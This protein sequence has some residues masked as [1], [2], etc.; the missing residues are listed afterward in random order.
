MIEGNKVVDVRKREMGTA[1]KIIEEF[2]IAA[3]E[4][5]SEKFSVYRRFLSFTESMKI[6]MRKKISN[7]FKVP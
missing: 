1:N 5:V 2:M 6:R 3:N 7:I 4:L